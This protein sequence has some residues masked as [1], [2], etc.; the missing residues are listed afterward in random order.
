MKDS[1]CGER[2]KIYKCVSWFF[3]DFLKLVINGTPRVYLILEQC[4]YDVTTMRFTQEAIL[5][6]KVIKKAKFISTVVKHQ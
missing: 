1:K 3:Y 2:A 5:V 4:R 6:K